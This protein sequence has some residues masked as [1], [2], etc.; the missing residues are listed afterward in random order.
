[1]DLGGRVCNEQAVPSGD[2]KCFS[3]F[4]KAYG[5]FN[6]GHDPHSLIVFSIPLSFSQFL[7]LKRLYS[8]YISICTHAYI[9]ECAT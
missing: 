2:G 8:V 1:M 5:S 3:D 7:L 6:R 9:R 4:K